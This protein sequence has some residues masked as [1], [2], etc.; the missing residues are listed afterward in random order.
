MK[1]N[2]AAVALS[3]NCT[4][5]ATYLLASMRAL[6]KVNPGQEFNPKYVFC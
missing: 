6:E 1:T 4:T 5:Q 2:V 3:A